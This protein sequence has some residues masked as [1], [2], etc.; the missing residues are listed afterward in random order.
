[1]LCKFHNDEV[2]VF[3][4]KVLVAFENILIAHWIQH[5]YFIHYWLLFSWNLVDLRFFYDFNGAHKAIL[6]VHCFAYL[7]E[8][9]LTYYLTEFVVFS[10]AFYIFEWVMQLDL[11]TY[12]FTTWLWRG[13]SRIIRGN[14]L[15]L[16]FD[17]D[18]L[19]AAWALKIID[20]LVFL[21]IFPIISYRMMASFFVLIILLCTFFTTQFFATNITKLMVRSPT[22]L[23]FF[24]QRIWS[25]RIVLI[26]EF[27][28]QIILACNFKITN[29]VVV[30]DEAGCSTNRLILTHG[31]TSDILSLQKLNYKE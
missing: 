7:T 8:S 14:I 16:F 26:L 28:L 24:A 2:K 1:M 21:L 29:A 30:V 12:L 9:T 25:I 31:Q 15:F 3:T 22:G 18:V 17:I 6:T 11:A 5:L 27:L 20:I 4:V 23:I 19:P 13:V 10:Y